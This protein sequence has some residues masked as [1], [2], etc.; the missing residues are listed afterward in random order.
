[1]TYPYPVFPYT[2]TEFDYWPRPAIGTACDA[3]EAD[4]LIRSERSDRG[5]SPGVWLLRRA[6]CG[7]LP[8]HCAETIA[9]CNHI[10]DGTWDL[11]E[12]PGG[13]VIEVTGWFRANGARREA[14]ESL[15]AAEH[16]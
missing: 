6:F 9:R 13:K 11:C 4:R 3:S 12:R 15:E 5:E 16:G 2:E 1:M 14:P 7:I 10:P 8:G